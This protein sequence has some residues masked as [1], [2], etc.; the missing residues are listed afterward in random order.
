MKVKLVK[1]IGCHTGIIDTF[2]TYGKYFMRW[3]FGESIKSEGSA[4][5]HIFIAEGF[6]PSTHPNLFSVMDLKTA[7]E[8]DKSFE[9][10]KEFEKY[11]KEN[12]KL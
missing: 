12:L 1:S 3:E 8:I 5:C 11:C 10:V 9:T 7:I 4:G 2:A 6:D